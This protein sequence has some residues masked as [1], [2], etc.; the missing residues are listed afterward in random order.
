MSIINSMFGFKRPTY[1][2]TSSSIRKLPFIP[3]P[4]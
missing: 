1:N 2:N 4:V 3:R